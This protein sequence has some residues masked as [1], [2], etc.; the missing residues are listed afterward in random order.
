MTT[1]DPAP[2]PN[3]HSHS[4]PY[5]A[6]ET[7]ATGSADRFHG[8][9]VH[10]TGFADDDGSADPVLTQAMA[11]AAAARQQ[12]ETVAAGLVQTGTGQDLSD[13]VE[14]LRGGRL[15]VAL[16][17]VLDSTDPLGSEKDSHLAAAMWSRPDGRVGLLAFSSVDAMRRWRSDAR[18]LPTAAATVAQAALQDGADALV[19][20]LAG[21]ATVVIEGP[22]LWAV[23]EGRALLAADQDSQVAKRV[24]AAVHRALGEI[25]HRV[26]ATD[27]V[28][29]L[30]LLGS[31]AAAAPDA[32]TA[33]ATDLA[34]DPVLRSR[35]ARGIHI[36]VESN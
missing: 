9:Q 28:D 25:S 5:G 20:D 24:A 11:R 6:A 19:L 8:A 4:H 23:A 16:V 36:G 22:A 7:H 18:P 10:D 1:A 21:P 3:P 35:V 34:Q 14:A 32:V 29:L 15:L 33:L 2:N 31:E 27:E 30:V 17:A 13:V 12:A 26:T